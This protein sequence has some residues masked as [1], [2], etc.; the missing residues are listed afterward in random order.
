MAKITHN[1]EPPARPTAHQEYWDWHNNYL[2]YEYDPADD[3]PEVEIIN[4]LLVD[5]A[6]A[7]SLRK[8]ADELITA[9]VAD[10]LL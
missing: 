6:W 4:R 1:G 3:G 9:T 2:I 7:S 8:I 5:V 10:S